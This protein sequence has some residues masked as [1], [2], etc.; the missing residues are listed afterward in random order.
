MNSHR[1]LLAA[2]VLPVAILLAGAGV[3]LVV[4]SEKAYSPPSGADAFAAAPTALVVEKSPNRAT[5]SKAAVSRNPVAAL[6]RK[7]KKKR[8]AAKRN[9]LKRVQQLLK[10]KFMPLRRAE[11]LA[12]RVAERVW[13]NNA[14]GYEWTDFGLSDCR[15]L[16]R[17]SVSCAVYVYFEQDEYGYDD[18]GSSYDCEWVVN[19]QYLRGG[20]LRVTSGF[21][22]RSCE[23][24]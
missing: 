14:G 10:P 20:K 21:A 13:E 16:S 3:G 4:A 18:Y 17:S 5:G 19:S 24:L 9:C 7:C 15:R 8:G 6:K 22:R 11:T 23:W 12:E 1:K 2:L